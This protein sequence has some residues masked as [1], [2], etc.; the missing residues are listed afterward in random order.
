MK[1][2]YMAL[3]IPSVLLSQPQ[4][5]GVF[6]GKQPS[7][8]QQG[9]MPQLEPHAPLVPNPAPQMGAA[10]P[11]GSR[12]RDDLGRYPAMTPPGP[13]NPRMR[14]N[15]RRQIQYATPYQRQL[16]RQARQEFR[17]RVQQILRNNRY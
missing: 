15:F 5:R 3:L 13:K 16:I 8:P 1:V 11:P 2:L 14:Q 9:Q 17:W 7:K 12:M 4:Q 10:F 6:P